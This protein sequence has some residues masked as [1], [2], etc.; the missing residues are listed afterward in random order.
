MLP[1]AKQNICSRCIKNSRLKEAEYCSRCIVEVVEKRVKSKLGALAGSEIVLEC[2]SKKS[3]QCNVAAYLIKRAAKLRI[4][5]RGMAKNKAVVTAKCADDLAACFLEKITGKDS[6][7][8]A[9]HEAAAVNILESITEKDLELYADIK[10][11][12]YTKAK[13]RGV[14][15]RIQALQARHPGT[16]EALAKSARQLGEL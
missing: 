12:K 1:I 3:L 16:I 10:R 13:N 5:M 2:G 8:P 9:K 6:L 14:K 11:I 15:Q 7:L 4:P